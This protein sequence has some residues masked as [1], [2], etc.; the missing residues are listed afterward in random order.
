M[1][2]RRRGRG[3]L[4]ARAGRAT[5]LLHPDGS[6]SYASSIAFPLPQVGAR[7]AQLFAERIA[8]PGITPRAFAILSNIDAGDP[9]GSLL[10]SQ[11]NELIPPL[12]DQLS[13]GLM[14]GETATLVALL[15][16][17]AHGA[18]LTPAVHPHLAGRARSRR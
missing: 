6:T 16:R 10:V 17:I 11:V 7:S 9:P 4:R 3:D 12:A 1:R 13:S 15:T 8:P 5:P 2:C 14:R 18:G